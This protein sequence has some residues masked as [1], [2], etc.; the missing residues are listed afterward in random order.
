MRGGSASPP[1]STWGNKKQFGASDSYKSDTAFPTPPPHPGGKKE[2]SCEQLEQLGKQLESWGLDS[3]QILG[4]LKEKEM[5]AEKKRKAEEHELADSAP[6][7]KRKLVDTRLRAVQW[8][9]EKKRALVEKSKGRLAEYSA[10]M[11]VME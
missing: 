4:E 10:E 3:S 11:Q 8:E 7:S 1:Q 9:V 5:E 2:S 6:K